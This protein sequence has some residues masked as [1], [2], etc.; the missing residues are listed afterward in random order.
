M[1]E[2]IGVVKSLDGITAKV[3]VPRKSA[4]DGCTLGTCKPD[5]QSM[6]IETFNQAG[7]K[8][9]QK[10]KVTMKTFTYM[11]GSMLVYGIPAVSLVI[12]AVLGKEFFSR[13]FT[14][15]D[16][17]VLSAIFGFCALAVSFIIVRIWINK[18]SKR[19][20]TKPIIEEILN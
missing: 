11:K 7:A 15:I 14:G 8:I 5:D 2:E 12:G 13:F 16:S 3:I 6:E 19:V 4:C 18:A 10:V 1:T 17:D 9:G 20:E